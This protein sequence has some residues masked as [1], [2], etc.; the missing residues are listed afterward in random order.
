[1]FFDISATFLRSP[2]SNQNMKSSPFAQ[3]LDEVTLQA[4]KKDCRQAQ[5]RVYQT[6]AKPAWTL[7][8]RLSGCEARAWDAV[9]E[10]F[11][12]AFG[13]I[14]QLRNS[15]SFGFWLRRILVNQVM[16]QH[17]HTFDSLPDETADEA[18]PSASISNWMDIERALAR[19]SESDRW[20]VWL[21]DAEGMTHDEIAELAGQ[22]KSWSKSRLSRA[23]K[24]L[25]QQCELTKVE[26]SGLTMQ[27]ANNV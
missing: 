13:K 9:Q 24:R 16:D 14:S 17:R 11:L 4:L 20:V 8:V 10:A 15:N 12:Q 27:G 18:A 6:Y 5:S 26:P 2:A 25:Q 23:R 1:M 7:A 22:T 3:A 19:L 21:H